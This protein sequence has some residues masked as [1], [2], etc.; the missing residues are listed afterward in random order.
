M[1]DASPSPVAAQLAA[2]PQ[3][4]IKALWS[5]WDQH[6]PR[7]PQN[8]NRCYLVS[9]LAYKLQEI[10]YG[11]LPVATRTRLANIGQ[12]YSKIQAQRTPSVYLAP[13]TVLLREFNCVEYRV[14][15]T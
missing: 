6:F 15:V 13:G 3:L 9:R 5:L 12:R 1:N 14:T 11:G 2:L 4:P 7:R 10:V 8:S